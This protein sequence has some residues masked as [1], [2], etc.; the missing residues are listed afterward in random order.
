MGDE[1]DQARADRFISLADALSPGRIILQLQAQ[2][3]SEAVQNIIA[4]I[5]R[6]ELPANPQMIARVVLKREQAMPTY[7]GHGLAVPHGRLDGIDGPVLAFARSDEGVP[8][9]GTNERA[10]LIFLLL[11]PSGMARIQP[12]LIADIIHLFDSE[13][14]TERLRKAETPE[15]VIEAIRA[16]QE[17]AID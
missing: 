10:E 6:E 9:E 17:M 14:V 5:P 12:R 2:S 1:F 13:Y 3:M 15:E 16:G 11:T 4:H 8:I 7:I